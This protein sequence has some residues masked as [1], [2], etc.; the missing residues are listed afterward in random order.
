MILLIGF[1][2]L[3]IIF[4]FLCSIWEAVLLS[5]TPS[6]IKR[7][8]SESPSTSELI[9]K[10]KNDI[11]KPLSAILT[12]NTIAHTVGAIGVGAQAGALYGDNSFTLLNFSIA[13]E[14]VIATIMTLAILFLSEIFPK[15]IGANNWES[16]APFTAKCLKILLFILKPFVWVSNL[17]TK[18][19]KKD[20]K[21]S[22]FSKQ[23]FVAMTDIATE[24]GEIAQNDSTFIKNILRF[25]ELTA[26][27][28]MTPRTVMVVSQE[29]QSLTDFF[30]KNRPFRF[31]RIPLYKDNPN[32][33]TGVLLKDDVLEHIIAE[34]KETKSIGEIKR[35]VPHV[36]I[37]KSLRDTF[38]DIISQK[39][40]MAIVINEYGGVAGLL[41]LEDII[42]TLFGL[43]IMDET[44]TISDLQAHARKIW[45]ERAKKMGL[46]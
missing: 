8:E 9:S 25:D 21:K 18:T 35:S 2:S 33:I 41:T 27:D 28:I 40:H 22:I 6:Y 4:S 36:N 43:E 44:D 19:L 32:V 17:L 31:S 3:S 29:D 10:L 42:E 45:N 12:L 13:Y 20:K 39:G 30:N 7:L 24:S 5:I 37:N 23:D 26:K 11:D 15:T 14:S 46:I 38:D 16:L 1:L 34:E